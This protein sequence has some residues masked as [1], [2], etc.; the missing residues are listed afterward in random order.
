MWPESIWNI[1]RTDADSRTGNSS[2]AAYFSTRTSVSADRERYSAVGGY[3]MAERYVALT[4]AKRSPDAYT[5]L[6]SNQK[7]Q[8]NIHQEDSK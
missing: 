6:L 2:V 7:K 4:E 3:T 1:E 5:L 8:E